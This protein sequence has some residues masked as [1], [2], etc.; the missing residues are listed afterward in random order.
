VKTFFLA[1]IFVAAIAAAIRALIE[2]RR[3]RAALGRAPLDQL[4]RQQIRFSGT[5][6]KFLI[7]VPPSYTPNAQLPLLLVFHGGGG[8]A[9]AIAA[10]SRMHELAKEEQFIAVYPQGTSFAVGRG[11]NWNA[12]GNPPSGWAE[13][14]RI[15]DIGFVRELIA[16]LC[17]L[18][19]IDKRHIYVAGLSKGGMLAYHVACQ[20]SDTIAAAGVVA[21]TMTAT[22]CRPR[23][24]VAIM[25]VHGTDDQ[26]VPFDGGRG[27]HTAR[28]N[29]WPPVTRGLA[30]WRHH[31]GCEPTPRLIHQR[32]KVRCW[33]YDA[34]T[35]R[36]D[37]RLCLI[38]G[39]GHGWPGAR[40]RHSK[41][42]LD[43]DEPFCATR[44]LWGF[45]REH[46]KITD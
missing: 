40:E 34:I 2:L 46:P 21:C 29:I 11:S 24:P 42:L 37:V 41:P 13:R 12:G 23:G 26:N 28:R 18:Y 44:A 33:Q 3:A 31:N 20:L 7:Y 10:Q 36:A 6:R 8:S 45:F 35:S 19:P 4:V 15:D 32:G 43:A 16:R 25:H 38:D 30:Y 5:V 9:A 1:L 17:S 22:E 39:G 27:A 14:H